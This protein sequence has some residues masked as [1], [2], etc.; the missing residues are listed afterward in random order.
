[1]EETEVGVI[2]YGEMVVEER[3]R[4]L[5]WTIPSGQGRAR[6]WNGLVYRRLVHDDRQSKA[7]LKPSHSCRAIAELDNLFPYGDITGRLLDAH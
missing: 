3:N 1:L 2:Q 5:L 4:S 7:P 6:L